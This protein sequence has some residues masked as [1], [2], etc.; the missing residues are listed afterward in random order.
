MLIPAV[1]RKSLETPTPTV[2]G[3]RLINCDV[4]AGAAI[5][6][7]AS[8]KE[9]HFNLPAL[10]GSE[11]QIGWAEEIR[12]HAVRKL[13][14]VCTAMSIIIEAGGHAG[15]DAAGAY[16]AKHVEKGES[17]HWLC[18]LCHSALLMFPNVEALCRAVEA[19]S[20]AHWWID[21]RHDL[22]SLVDSLSKARVEAS[23]TSGPKEIQAMADAL[24]RPEGREPF[25]VPAEVS[26][27]GG[28][29]EVFRP[30]KSDTFRE[31][32]H[33]RGYAWD[34]E[35]SVWALKLD[36]DAGDPM[37][38]V[39]EITG[40]LVGAGYCVLC[41]DPDARKAAL[42]GEWSPMS[43]RRIRRVDGRFSIVWP[44]GDDWYR[45]AKTVPGA[46]WNKAAH[47]MAVPILSAEAVADFADE[48][49]FSFT[50]GARALLESF[51]DAV[52]MGCV[53]PASKASGRKKTSKAK[54][55]A[56]A[57]GGVDPEL[58]DTDD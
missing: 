20:N 9:I 55:G 49:D 28:R 19:Q 2:P 47:E 32:M 46:K 34:G 38:R 30:V 39:A 51:R 11:K 17:L 10:E 16:L 45:E 35:A 50:P 26:R 8:P 48:Y 27:T 15:V 22:H 44:Y 41:H 40:V 54:P 24:V 53:L 5:L 42:A 29:V 14:A 36:E 12:E 31:I 33:G 23:A 56:P 7:E 25:K 58:M 21:H 52:A 1:V 43:S 13:E 18:Q 6:A 37:E 57:P 4:K 3:K